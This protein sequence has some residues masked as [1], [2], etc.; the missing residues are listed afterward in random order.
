MSYTLGEF[1]PTLT[2]DTDAYFVQETVYPDFDVIDVMFEQEETLT[3]I[4]VVMAPI[5]IINDFIPP[6]N[7]TKDPS[8]PDWV[9]L[10]IMI[11]VWC[12]LLRFHAI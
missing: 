12:C 4:P 5:D 3:V 10:L 6:M 2:S 1:G 9:K 11:L 7:T 8:I